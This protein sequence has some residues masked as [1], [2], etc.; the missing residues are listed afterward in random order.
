MANM[1]DLDNTPSELITLHRQQEAGLTRWQLTPEDILLQLEQDLRGAIYN[2][3]TQRFEIPEDADAIINER[4]I[5]RIMAIVRSKINKVTFLSNLDTDDVTEITRDV[6]L[7]LIPVLFSSY[8]YFNLS[9]SNIGLLIDQ[10]V[11]L[12]YMGLLRALDEGERN[13]LGKAEKRMEVHRMGEGEE[14]KGIFGLFRK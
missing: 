13:F 10:V 11:H 14:K 9:L 7:E 3:D 1:K 8:T 6:N 12:V 5:R 2:S 4:G